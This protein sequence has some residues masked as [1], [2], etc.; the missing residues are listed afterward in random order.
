MSN[1]VS[2]PRL[3]IAGGS[4]GAGKTTMMLIL[5]E[6]LRRCG[7][8]V[9][10]FK[11]GP[12]YLDPSY[13]KLQSGSCQNLDGWLMG[14]EAVVHTFVQSVQKQQA[15]IALIEGM[16][17]LFDGASARSDAG[18]S[19]EIAK[20]L[21]AP[22]LVTLDASGIARTVDA[23]AFG[24]SRYDPETQVKGV[25]LNRLGSLGHLNLLKESCQSLA[26]LA[27]LPQRESLH[28]PERHLGLVSALDQKSLE[29]IYSEVDEL[30]A[31]WIDLPAIIEIARQ[32][33]DLTYREPEEKKSSKLGRSCRIAYAFDECFHF[34]YEDNLSR[35]RSYGAELLKFSPLHDRLLP[36]CDGVYLGGGYPEVY[37]EKLAS[38]SSM[39][40]SIREHATQN[41]PIY[42]E[43]GGLMYLAQTLKLIDGHSYPMLGLLPVKIRMYDHLQAIGYTEVELKEDNFLGKVGLR[44][45]GHQFRYSDFETEAAGIKRVYQ[46]K[47]GQQQA[48]QAEGY[49]LGSVLGS[50]IH[51]HWASN[52]LICKN[53][54]TACQSKS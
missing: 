22:V 20:W 29:G 36:A 53:F 24:L 21:K 41:K 38:N 7:L 37:A 39:M 28:L 17:G 6:G 52:P 32:A 15:D 12:D 10:C 2:I 43:C 34:Y 40:Q 42:G 11:C 13:H 35:L 46:L 44:F 16:M 3:L 33:E 27:G 30:I 1:T 54:V 19:A 14:K 9:A 5:A 50:Y 23:L 25:L 45:R 49:Q 51:A 4:S 26:V 31:S 18:S 8:K 48:G 47:I